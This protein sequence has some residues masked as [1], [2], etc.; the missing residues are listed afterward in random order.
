MFDFEPIIG[1]QIVAGFF[2]FVSFLNGLVGSP[3]PPL[4]PF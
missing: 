1:Q 3:P 4:W 2:A